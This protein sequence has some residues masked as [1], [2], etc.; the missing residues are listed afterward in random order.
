MS[1]FPNEAKDIKLLTPKTTD[2]NRIKFFFFFAKPVT[3]ADD[4]S[5]RAKLY[6]LQRVLL[7]RRVYNDSNMIYYKILTRIAD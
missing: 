3:R 4:V 6:Y 5:R 1:V 7:I 2:Q